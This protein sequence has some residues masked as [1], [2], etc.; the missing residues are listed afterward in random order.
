MA[1]SVETLEKVKALCQIEK[2]L[3]KLQNEVWQVIESCTTGLRDNEIQD[4]MDTIVKG[5]KK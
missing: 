3:T 4:L 5:V 2:Q 1:V